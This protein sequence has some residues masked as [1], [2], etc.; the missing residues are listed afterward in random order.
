MQSRTHILRAEIAAVAVLLC[1]PQVCVKAAPNRP[2]PTFDRASLDN[3]GDDIAR[4]D[5]AADAENAPDIRLFAADER[6]SAIVK[7]AGLVSAALAVV[8]LAALLSTRSRRLRL[9]QSRERH[10]LQLVG[11]L[12]LGSRCALQLVQVDDQRF[13]VARDGSG[14]SSVTPVNSFATEF[15]LA[16]DAQLTSASSREPATR[17]ER[18]RSQPD[19]TGEIGY[20]ESSRLSAVADRG[21]SLESAQSTLSQ[22]RK[23]FLSEVR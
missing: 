6:I 21:L 16:D 3:V 13:L 7:R 2:L 17:D 14:L 9:A 4:P 19:D 12:A 5:R 23:P 10:A 18:P 8:T 15:E 20:R 1:V 11:S 22:G